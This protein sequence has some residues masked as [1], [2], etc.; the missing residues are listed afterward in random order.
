MATATVPVPDSEV[1]VEEWTIAV[2]GDRGVGKTFLARAFVFD[3]FLDMLPW[4][5][6][7][8]PFTKEL[9]VDNRNCRIVIPD[10]YDSA[11]E[12]DTAAP[13]TQWLSPVQGILLI[14][15][16][17]SRE[18]FEHIRAIH[19]WAQRH[20]SS[21]RTTAVFVLAGNKADRGDPQR[22]ARVVS[23]DEGAA[24]AKELQMECFLETSAKT[25]QNVFRV[26]PIVVRAARAKKAEIE[27]TERR[28]RESKRR[29]VVM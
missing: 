19:A 28:K 18:S 20:A 21:A 25:A 24:L 10:D 23:K 29:C 3:S 5:D 26:F 11:S 1:P 12:L 2:L 27:E 8:P 4:Q 9:L 7:S 17:D 13:A 22:G 6:E 15:S 16:I 14:Y